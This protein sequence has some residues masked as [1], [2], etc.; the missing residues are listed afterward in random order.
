MS[1]RE[2]IV[3]ATVAATLLGLAMVP[4]ALAAGDPVTVVQTSANLSQ[5][6]NPMRATRLRPG[7]PAPGTPVIDIDDSVLYQRVEGFGAAMTDSSA[8]LIER[9]LPHAT[10]A[11]LMS[12]VFGPD[13]LHLSFLRVP[14]GAS[15]FTVGGRPYSYDDRPRGRS[16]P[17]L[18]HFSI[19]HDRAYILPALRAA[20]AL[21]PQL[22]T[23]ATPWSAPAWMKGNDSLD[24]VGER[25]TLRGSAYGPWAGYIVKFLQ[26]YA[27]AGVPIQA[28]T[29]A[30]EPGNPTRYPGMNMSSGSI[31]IWIS[32]FLAPALERARLHPKLYAAD[33]GWG[34]P[35][36]AQAAIS[37][38]A[39][40]DLSGIAWH[41]YFGSPSVMSSLHT[42][43]PGLDEI[44]DECSPG[45]SAIPVSEVVISSLREWASTVALWNLAL[46]PAGGPVQAPNT[47]CP[48]CT[49]LVMINPRGGTVTRN[50]AWYQLGQASEFVEVG[51]RRVA[52][53]TFVNYDYLKPGVNFITT[54]LDDVAFVNP[55][56][57]RVLIAYNN[58]PARIT[59]AVSWHGSYFEY[60]LPSH[61]TVTFQW[62]PEPAASS[63]TP[64]LPASG[65]G[66]QP[67][68]SA[69][70]RAARTRPRSL[71]RG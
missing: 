4:G 25:G 11:Q 61:A 24:D 3:G 70:R 17:K 9:R 23:L 20:L 42:R 22:Q 68:L 60:A 43:V 53:N 48:G 10:S 44:V 47:G 55:D 15:D 66:V 52:S 54:S 28:L 38:P 26:A 14:I 12:D 37:G 63:S 51:A 46:N 35:S 16:D 59:F 41:C 40:P 2:V 65:T 1:V 34:T 49:G 33:Y 19:A 7:G 8:W 58:S 18:R 13:G 64:A 50:L 36:A 21:N 6:L 57:D 56:G 67:D 32:R 62:G 69:A 27:A 39:A 5:A 71:A 45:I 31:A 29:P 30:N